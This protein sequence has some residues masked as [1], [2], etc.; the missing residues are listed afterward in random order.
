M[1]SPLP[2]TAARLRSSPSYTI[3]V[4]SERSI[5]DATLTQC[6]V[7]P[8]QRACSSTAISAHNNIQY[9]QRIHSSCTVPYLRACELSVD[10]ARYVI[11]THLAVDHTEVLAILRQSSQ[12]ALVSCWRA[13]SSLDARIYLHCLE[14]SISTKPDTKKN[15]SQFMSE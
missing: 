9:A 15:K 13:M 10:E 12:W 1:S 6:A 5:S 14:R 8:L 3:S 2:A 11:N 7:R 4:V